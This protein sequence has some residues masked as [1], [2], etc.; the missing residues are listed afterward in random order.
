[1]H[2]Y[3]PLAVRVAT[4]R[5]ELLAATDDLLDQLAPLV[6][7]GDADADPP[8]Y[9]DPISLYTD[10]PDERVASWL[11]GIW[12]GRGTFGPETWRLYFVV[13]IDGR[14]VGMQDII[15]DHFPVYGTVTTFS[16]LSRTVRGRGLGREMRRAALHL[17]FDR[18]GATEAGSEAFFDNEASNGVSRS[19]GYEPNGNA[20]ASRRGEA[21][22]LERW[23][24]TRESWSRTRS[25]DV[26]VQGAEACRHTLGMVRE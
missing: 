24:L 19:L 26:V 17:A 2:S 1:M 21:A 15:G 9:D 20:W 18:L 6:R 4:P 3:A 8:P 10:D 22:L 14:P 12:R 11:R 5:L 16:W 23:R 7:A 13:I 25:D